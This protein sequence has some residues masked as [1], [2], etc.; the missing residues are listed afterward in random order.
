MKIYDKLY[1]GGEWVPPRGSGAFEVD[2]SS[3]EEPIGKVPAGS[4]E[5][6]TR[7]VEAAAR[8]FGP[9]SETPLEE[10]AQLLE[11]IADGLGARSDELARTIAAEVGMPLKL[12]AA[13]QVG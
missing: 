2:N 7:A 13:I 5:D 9:W 11:R 10:R 12:A 3:N 1:I 6:A 8:A 4:A